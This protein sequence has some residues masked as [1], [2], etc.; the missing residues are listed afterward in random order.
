MAQ[1]ITLKVNVQLFILNPCLTTG[2][3]YCQ[4]GKC[5]LQSA[6]HRPL[7]YGYL[8]CQTLHSKGTR[9][10]SYNFCFGHC[11]KIYSHLVYHLHEGGG[12][13]I[14]LRLLI[15]SGLA[16]WQFEQLP[17]LLSVMLLTCNRKYV[18]IEFSQI[19][20][21]LYITKHSSRYGK[22]NTRVGLLMY[23]M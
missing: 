5:Q 13:Y 2:N 10:N 16:M 23:C 1:T 20:I 14:I 9:M 6:F 21:N 3:I 18:K 15:C 17:S 4:T 7:S 22:G 8:P 11:G 19:L 12:L